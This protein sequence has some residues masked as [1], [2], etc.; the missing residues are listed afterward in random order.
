M[1]TL[2]ADALATIAP[3]DVV[4]GAMTIDARHIA[5]LD[6][7]EAA[8]IAS[9]R[10]ARAAEFATGRA[11]L[12]LLLPGAGP[13]PRGASG[14]PV[15]PIGTVG[16]LAHDDQYVVA[17]IR[18]ATGTS[19]S[20]STSNPRTTPSATA[21]RGSCREEVLRDDDPII[22][23]VAGFVMK[24]AA[25][26]AW[27]GL[28]GEVVGPL[29]VRLTIDENRFIAHMPASPYVVRG[30]FRVVAGRWLA[31]ATIEAGE[32]ELRA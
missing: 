1:Q 4:G 9:A 8:A 10:A 26:K 25:Y 27:S 15:W 30:V 32:P 28:G 24:E 5:G 22:S 21:T 23:P 11:L 17:A 16:S 7:S 29:A 20:V 13:I 12:H 14:A 6:P 18:D 3:A 31:L 2:L 19:A